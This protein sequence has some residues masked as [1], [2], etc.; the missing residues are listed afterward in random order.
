LDGP[1]MAAVDE[2]KITIEGKGAHAATPQEGVDPIV[3]AAHLVTALQSIVSRSTDP[4]ETAVVTIGKIE[5]GTA[6]N[7]IPDK[8][9]MIGTVR[10]F[11]K[12]IHKR[13]RTRM[14]ALVK[15]VCAAFGARGT[16]EYVHSNPATVN[17][18]E[19]AQFFRG[20]ASKT[21]GAKAVID[22]APTMGGEDFAFYGEKV[23][24]CYAFLGS[25]PRSGGVHMHHHPEFNPD[26]GVL[27]LG[28]QLMHDAARTWLENAR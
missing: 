1:A 22:C 23:P 19:L 14:Q 12:A 11:N 16:L 3:V 2:L 17:T 4:L 10:T 6:F 8:V 25:A 21:L 26:E 27:H 13:V 18:P 15:S 20:T 9:T 7:I 5:G 28:A 24:S